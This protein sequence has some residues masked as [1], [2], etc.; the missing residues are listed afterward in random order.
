MTTPREGGL[1]STSCV[2]VVDPAGHGV[3]ASQLTSQLVEQP[4]ILQATS[5]SASQLRRSESSLRPASFGGRR[6]SSSGGRRASWEG[7][8]NERARRKQ[9]AKHNASGRWG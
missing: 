2:I 9:L 7:K 4:N 1:P 6:P 5:Q 8:E 3:H